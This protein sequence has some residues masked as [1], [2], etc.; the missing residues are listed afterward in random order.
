MLKPQD[1]LIVLKYWSIARSGHVLSVR[2]LAET[3]GIS[4]S[5]VSKAS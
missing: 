2:D 1:T 4:A 5:E 3:V